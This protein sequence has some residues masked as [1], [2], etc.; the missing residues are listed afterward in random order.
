[1]RHKAFEH[2]P[3][4]MGLINESQISEEI[5][6]RVM[7]TKYGDDQ[8]AKNARLYIKKIIEQSG[9]EGTDENIDRIINY[10]NT[11]EDMIKRTKFD[12]EYYPEILDKYIE[13]SKKSKQSHDH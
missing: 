4:A 10:G 8:T 5:F 13:K 9:A 7:D 2:D 1:M 11:L 3:I 12:A 6:T